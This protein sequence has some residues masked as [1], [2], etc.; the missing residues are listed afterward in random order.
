MTTTSQESNKKRKANILIQSTSL[1][2]D[3]NN[4][5][6]IQS[7]EKVDEEYEKKL[8]DLDSMKVEEINLLKEEKE[9][10]DLKNKWKTKK[11]L[12]TFANTVLIKCFDLLFIFK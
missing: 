4:N 2:T 9:W 10:K 6:F 11:E 1:P 3:D 8:H 5:L 7:I 12:F